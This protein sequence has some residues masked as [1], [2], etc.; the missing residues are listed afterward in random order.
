MRQGKET[1]IQALTTSDLYF[2]PFRIEQ[3]KRLWWGTQRVEIR[4][5]PVAVLRYLERVAEFTRLY[6]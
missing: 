6:S 4:P 2:S 5:R 3:G 1:Q